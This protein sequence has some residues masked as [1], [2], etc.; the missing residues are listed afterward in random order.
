MT[1]FVGLLTIVLN[2]I[3]AKPQPTGFAEALEEMNDLIESADSAES[4]E[5]EGFAVR[6]TVVKWFYDYKQWITTTTPEITTRFL[7]SF[8]HKQL[9]KKWK[10]QRYQRII[11]R[12]QLNLLKLV[13]A[14]I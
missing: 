5:L 10:R 2:Y 14:S 4:N 9:K 13:Q 7:F 12:L 6:R 11:H 3:L 1:I 8:H